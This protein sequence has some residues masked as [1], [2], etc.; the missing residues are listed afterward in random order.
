MKTLAKTL[1]LT[2]AI[3]GLTA[4]TT[5]QTPSAPAAA[6]S[7]TRTGVVNDKAYTRSSNG[8]KAYQGKAQDIMGYISIDISDRKNLKP[9]GK[10]GR[11]DEQGNLSLSVPKDVSDDLL[12]VTNE[13]PTGKMAETVAGGVLI[14]KPNL[15]IWKADNDVMVLTYLSRD[16]RYVLDGVDYGMFRKG[17]NYAP[18]NG[19]KAQTDYGDYKWVLMDE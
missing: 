12:F 10:I 9:I 1:V 5:A 11:I 6:Q 14:T 2:A 15:Q 19:H 18:M 4:C 13:T 7:E 17:W 16:Y 8:A 3:A